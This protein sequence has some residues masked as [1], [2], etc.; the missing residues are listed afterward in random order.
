MRFSRSGVAALSSGGGPAQEGEG[1]RLRALFTNWLRPLHAL[2]LSAEWGQS[3]D[4]VEIQRCASSSVAKSPTYDAGPY[5]VVTA[6]AQRPSLII[7]VWNFGFSL[8]PRIGARRRSDAVEMRMFIPFSALF[9]RL[10]TI[11][12]LS[13]KFVW[14]LILLWPFSETNATATRNSQKAAAWRGPRRVSIVETHEITP[15]LLG[16]SRQGSGEGT[17]SRRRVLLLSKK[18]KRQRLGGEHDFGSLVDRFMRLSR[19]VRWNAIKASPTDYELCAE[20]TIIFSFD[21][22]MH[23]PP[24]FRIGSECSEYSF[25]LDIGIGITDRRPIPSKLPVRRRFGMS[26]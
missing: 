17:G 10:K 8:V 21:L 22:V 3:F 23:D 26:A 11:K 14:R 18:Q 2:G 19:C 6:T 5:P 9:Q 12:S 7:F 13:A 1:Q 4:L 16:V 20:L 25:T 24:G 15:Y